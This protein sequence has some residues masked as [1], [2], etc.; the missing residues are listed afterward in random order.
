M[1]QIWQGT[2]IFEGTGEILT[3][4]LILSSRDREQSM[5]QMC[6]NVGSISKLCVCSKAH[7]V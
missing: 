5:A 3:K 4:K 2:M 7:T 1:Q 6:S